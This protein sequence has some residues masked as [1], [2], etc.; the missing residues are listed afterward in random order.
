M[1]TLTRLWD[2]QFLR[3]KC[4]D[5]GGI[6]VGWK[7]AKLTAPVSDN[8]C[9]P[10][11]SEPLATSDSALRQR[12]PVPAWSAGPGLQVHC[13]AASSSKFPP[14]LADRCDSF[15]ADLCAAAYTRAPIE[16]LPGST[17]VLH[18]AVPRH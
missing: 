3:R 7:I 9:P 5:Q 12:R 18:R 8:H 15:W 14:P 6:S 13:S 2:L 16:P 17:A 11:I 4:V 10:R 1:M